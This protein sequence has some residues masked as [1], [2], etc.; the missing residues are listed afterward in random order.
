MLACLLLAVG[1][2][3]DPRR[4]ALQEH[5]HQMMPDV[6][7]LN[8]ASS[9]RP[10]R[11]AS[12]RAVG[13]LDGRALQ[14]HPT[15]LLVVP[16]LLPTAGFRVQA[17]RGLALRVELDPAVERHKLLVLHPGP[18]GQWGS[19]VWGPGPLEGLQPLCDP[20]LCCTGLAPVPRGW[21]P[22]PDGLQRGKP[23]ICHAK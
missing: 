13:A 19:R 11:D 14:L 2:P 8:I 20:L 16:V 21:A 5:A 3:I 9:G 15:K 17:C 12:C 23:A 6:D 4:G 7:L 1:L 10:V 18:L 22:E